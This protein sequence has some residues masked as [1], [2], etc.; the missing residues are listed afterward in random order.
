LS[1]PPSQ[2][3]MAW[4]PAHVELSASEREAIEL[5]MLRAGELPQARADELGD[6]LALPLAK[7]LRLRYSHPARFLG[8]LD[9]CHIQG[10]R[11]AR[12][13]PTSCTRARRSGKSCRASFP[14]TARCGSCCP[15]KFRAPPHCTARSART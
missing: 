1:P 6:I 2:A 11:L 10:G 15:A 5:F 14:P 8:L 13:P 7:R 12:A 3:E 4:L 9:H